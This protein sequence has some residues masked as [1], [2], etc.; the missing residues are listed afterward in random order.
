MKLVLNKNSLSDGEYDSA[1]DDDGKEG[2]DETFRKNRNI[3]PKVQNGGV[4]VNVGR[5]IKHF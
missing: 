5:D 1:D 4:Y 3:V 2:Y